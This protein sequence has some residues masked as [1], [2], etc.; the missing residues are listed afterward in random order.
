MKEFDKVFEKYMEAVKIE[1]E[2]HSSYN[3]GYTA[4]EKDSVSGKE[5]KSKAPKGTKEYEG[6]QKGYKEG[7]GKKECE[8]CGANVKKGEKCC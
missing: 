6:Y 5:S 8:R 2:P 7:K 3:T 4:G 1:R